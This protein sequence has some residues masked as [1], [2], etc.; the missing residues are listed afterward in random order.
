MQMLLTEL[1]NMYNFKFWFLKGKKQ[2]QQQQQQPPFHIDFCFGV[3]EIYF[4]CCIYNCFRF[5][6]ISTAS[7]FILNQK[8]KRIWQAP[9]VFDFHLQQ[10]QL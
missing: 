8:E 7:L 4:F 6:L 2:Q 3:F 10:E 1:D 9:V 5:T